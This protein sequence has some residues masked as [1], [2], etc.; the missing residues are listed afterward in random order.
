MS[1]L[2]ED[3]I[4]LRFGNLKPILEKGFGCC[5][6]CKRK[7]KLSDTTVT[8]CNVKPEGEIKDN[9]TIIFSHCNNNRQ[10]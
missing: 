1:A 10:Y 7:I 5:H 3:T 4:K 2:L 6:K 8:I 9:N